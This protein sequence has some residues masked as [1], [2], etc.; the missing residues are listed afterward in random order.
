MITEIKNTQPKDVL[1]VR[2]AVSNVC[3]YKC[4]YCFPGSNEGTYR[5]PTNVTQLIR[6]FNNIFDY[7]ETHLGKKRFHLRLLGGEPTIWSG[8]DTFI[9]GIKEKHNVYVSVI[10]N[11]SRTLRWWQENGDLIDN[12][13]ISYHKKFADVDHIISVADTVYMF[14]KKVTVHVLMDPSD[15]QGCIDD[16]MTMKQTSKYPWIIQTKKI[17]PTNRYTPVYSE[18]QNKFMRI[19]IK[20]LPSVWWFIKQFKLVLD[21]TMRLYESVYINDNKKY[22]ARAETY[23]INNDI[24]FKGYECYMGIESLYIDWN[25]ELKSSC[26][27]ELFN[28]QYNIFDSL[29]FKPNL[30][31][32]I[33]KQDSCYCPTENHVSKK[34]IKIVE[35]EA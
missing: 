29:E 20:R 3:N 33:C 4:E 1:D 15:W 9:K 25:G 17:T 31:P 27:Q 6:N 19:G 18:E 13:S 22:K 16:I 32:I 7:Y 34:Y 2:W 10:T 30:D 8:L 12:V 35:L 24:N 14:D 5:F 21:K 26:G 23:I 11:G 28:G